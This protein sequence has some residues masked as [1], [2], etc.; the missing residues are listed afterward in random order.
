MKDKVQEIIRE[1][2]IEGADTFS[3]FVKRQEILDDAQAY[4]DQPSVQ[5]Q[6]STLTQ[7]HAD[8][9]PIATVLSPDPYDDRDGVRFSLKD[10]ER[11]NSLPSGTSIYTSPQPAAQV[12]ATPKQQWISCKDRLPT[13]KDADENGCVWHAWKE[14]WGQWFVMQCKFES[15]SGYDYWM[16]TGLRRPQP[17]EIE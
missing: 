3:S 6:I 13:G 2:F 14:H 4:I 9:D 1:A 15:I 17:P 5:H 16:P 8:S 10:W 12:Q 7:H 11:L